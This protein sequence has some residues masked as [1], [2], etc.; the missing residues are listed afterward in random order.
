MYCAHSTSSIYTARSPYLVLHTY[1]KSSSSVYVDFTT[2]MSNIVR[3]PTQGRS[4]FP[5]LVRI[6]VFWGVPKII[7]FD[8]PAA[9]SPPRGGLS[10]RIHRWRELVLKQLCE[11]LFSREASKN[12][13]IFL[14]SS[15]R[16][17]EGRV[18]SQCFMLGSWRAV[19]HVCNPDNVSVK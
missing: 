2:H 18:E 15:Q 6:Q 4:F 19:D 5:S 3:I 17:E 16:D 7:Y 13:Y 9:N 1:N 14:G 8:T 11:A 12:S 10:N